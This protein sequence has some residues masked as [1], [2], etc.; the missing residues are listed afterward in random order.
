[1]VSKS[2]IKNKTNETIKRGLLN[3]LQEKM[4]LKSKGLTKQP[5]MITVLRKQYL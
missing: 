2:M 5:A 3:S 4:M 1:M